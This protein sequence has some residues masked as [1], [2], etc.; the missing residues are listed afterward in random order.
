M[1]N[2]S[3]YMLASGPNEELPEVSVSSYER[4]GYS[5]FR[6]SA[7][8]LTPFSHQRPITILDINKNIVIAYA[9]LL[10]EVSES[11]V[12]DFSQKKETNE[13]IIYL[14]ETEI[15]KLINKNNLL[16]LPYGKNY[17]SVR[18]RRNTY[19]TII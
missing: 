1:S 8:N 12:D 15:S 14:P 7:K 17:K 6:I 19:E 13:Y 10:E 2:I 18:K 9:L 3:I 11:K 16:I 4:A 5:E